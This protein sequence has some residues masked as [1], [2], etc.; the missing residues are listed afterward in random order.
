[1]REKRNTNNKKA[2][3]NTNTYNSKAVQKLSFEISLIVRV[4]IKN[5]FIRADYVSSKNSLIK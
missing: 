1:M 5:T 4:I 2:K 3:W